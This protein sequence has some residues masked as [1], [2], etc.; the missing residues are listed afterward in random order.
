MGTQ[1]SVLLVAYQ[2]ELLDPHARVFTA[3]GFFVQRAASLSAGLGA[4]GP[5]NVDLLVL[6]PGIPMGDRRR[7]EGEAKRR[8]H[9]IRIVL[10]Y[11][12]EKERDVFASAILDIATPAEEIVTHARQW[13]TDAVA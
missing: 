3:A 5:G 12:G 9:N 7:I 1:K 11:S 13:F 10:L 4:V 8:N 2:P 6:A